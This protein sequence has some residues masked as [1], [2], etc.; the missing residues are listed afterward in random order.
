MRNNKVQKIE[1]LR[2]VVN[3]YFSSICFDE[4]KHIYTVNG[5]KL[6]SVSSVYKMFEEKVDFDMIAF[7]V[8][9]ARAKKGE[10]ITKEDVLKEWRT[11][12]TKATTKGT[13]IHT[14]AENVFKGIV[15][16][17]N[18]E[19]YE[20]SVVNFWKSMPDYIIPFISELKMFSQ[21]L[22]IAG[23]CDLI[24]YN[25][26]TGKF[27]ILDYKTNEDLFKN[28]KKKNKKSG[29]KLLK[30]FDFLLDTPFNKYQLQLSMYKVLFE[31][32]GLEVESTKLVWLKEDG[33]YQV[34][35]TS[36]YSQL[37]LNE[38]VVDNES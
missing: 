13:K 6:K 3:N 8:A 34:F 36:D 12:G 17:G 14:F 28:Y 10:N 37:I 11:K 35:R 20:A 21:E 16:D 18:P 24:V 4:E 27:I 9:R 15:P 5:R 33:T 25:D 30:P 19:G 31:Q 1:E 29:K 2:E 22:G 38:I 23:T 7:Y 32:C 26:K